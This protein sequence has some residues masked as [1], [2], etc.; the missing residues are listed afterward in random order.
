M[1]GALGLTAYVFVEPAAMSGGAQ[2]SLSRWNFNPIVRM[3]G[4]FIGPLRR[5]YGL[6]AGFLFALSIRAVYGENISFQRAE[7]QVSSI[8]A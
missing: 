5:V 2:F 4:C 6:F 7:N 8:H 3:I 1:V